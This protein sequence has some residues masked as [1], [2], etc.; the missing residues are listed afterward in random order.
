MISRKSATLFFAICLALLGPASASAQGQELAVQPLRI[1]TV[2]AETDEAFVDACYELEGH[3]TSPQCDN[4]GDGVIEFANVPI[5]TYNLVQTADIGNL[6][7]IGAPGVNLQ[8]LEVVNEDINDVQ[9]SLIETEPSTEVGLITRDRE[10]G[11]VLEG[12]CYELAGYSN[13]GCDDDGNGII[14]FQDIPW[15]TY[16]VHQTETPAGYEPMGDYEIFVSPFPEAGNGSVIIPLIQAEEQGS[17]TSTNVSVL[18]VDSETGER[19]ASEETCLQFPGM[20]NPGCDDG[21]VDG[22]IDF[23]GVDPTRGQPTF[24]VQSL[25][26]G[27]EAADANDVLMHQYG[28]FNTVLV[29]QVNSVDADCE[30]AA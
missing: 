20:T 30:P 21:V 1:H 29:L 5:G 9:V 22:Q 28:E 27:Y 25:A 4:D 24:E 23:I 14:T 3:S 18:V 16:T 17:E 15:G 6:Y 26:C 12:A 13:V 10:S 19:V 7:P 2:L 11:D 8:A